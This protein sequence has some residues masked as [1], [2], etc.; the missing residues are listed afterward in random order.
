MAFPTGYS[1]LGTLTTPTITGTVTNIPLLIRFEDFTTEMLALLDVGG[2]DLVITS[3]EAGLTRLPI[4]VVK[5]DK[6][7]GYTRVRVRVPSLSTGTVLYIWGD[8]TGETQPAVTATFGRNETWQ[9]YLLSV[10]GRFDFDDATGLYTKVQVAGTETQDPVLGIYTDATNKI[11]YDGVQTHI[12]DF[13]ISSDVNV[14]AFDT[15][16][17]G[18]ASNNGFVAVCSRNSGGDRS[19]TLYYSDNGFGGRGFI[20]DGSSTAKGVADGDTTETAPFVEK[21]TGKFERDNLV[22][23]FRGYWSIWSDG[24]KGVINTGANTGNVPEFTH[25]NSGISIGD[26]PQWDSVATMHSRDIT[27]KRTTATDDYIAVMSANEISTV[28]WFTA[29][30]DG[31]TAGV[32]TNGSIS[33][34]TLGLAATVSVTL[35]NPISIGTLDLG[36]LSISVTALAGLP[37]PTSVIGID[38]SSMGFTGTAEVTLPQ[39]ESTISLELGQLQISAN[40]ST[41]AKVEFTVAFDIGSIEFELTGEAD[42]PDSTITGMFD[43]GSIFVSG[44]AGNSGFTLTPNES[45]NLRRS[46]KYTNLQ[47]TNKY[48]N[49]RN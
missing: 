28:A 19:G 21:M 37:K 33:L 15:G 24:V 27:I 23:G 14:T 17:F 13:V 9:D 5:F 35:P 39:P 7:V 38:L 46:S 18:S 16:L 22:S 6:T 43:L 2:G 42:L 34:S 20:S 3:D 29:A 40:A 47:R 1:L 30:N 45:V 31:P 32:S 41:A 36:A 44:Q 4:H 48:I 26:A 11:R 49:L 25:H 8:N 10:D 12:D